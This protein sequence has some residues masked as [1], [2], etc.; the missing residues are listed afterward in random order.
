MAEDFV[1][2][3]KKQRNLIIILLLVFAVTIGVLFQ[4]FFTGGDEVLPEEESYVKKPEIKLDFDILEDPIFDNLNSFPEIEP[5]QE[6]ATT[7]EV[8][9]RE[10]PFLP[11]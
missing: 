3:K 10:N 8:I 4:G 5:F 2:Q 1:S 6:N 7:G 11:Y 9:G